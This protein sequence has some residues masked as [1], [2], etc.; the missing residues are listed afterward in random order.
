MKRRKLYDHI[1]VKC[2]KEFQS[3]SPL[4]KYCSYECKR[5]TENARI[6]KYDHAEVSKPRIVLQPVT[7][8]EETE[9]ISKIAKKASDMNM[10]YGQYMA[11]EYVR[12]EQGHGK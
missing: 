11:M 3:H 9:T 8:P 10:S 7:E 5:E 12:K 2:G 6:R 4:S 1:C